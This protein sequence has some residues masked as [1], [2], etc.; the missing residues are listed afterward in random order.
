MHRHSAFTLVEL[1]VVIGVITVLI[2]MLSPMLARARQKSRS[3]ECQSSLRQLY[4]AQSYYASD[5][6]GVWSAP[7]FQGQQEQW[8]ARLARYFPA[9]EE[10][11]RRLMQCGEIDASVQPVENMSYGVNSSLLMPQWSRRF[12]KKYNS[13]R[14]IFMGEKVPNPED[15]L[16]TDDGFY[17]VRDFFGNTRWNNPIG[18]SGAGAFRHSRS[19]ANFVMADG[20]VHALE[21][22]QLH[23]DSGH[24][25]F[26][27]Y[28]GPVLSFLANCCQ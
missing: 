13:S 10:T 8:P 16:T 26:G 6:K 28:D 21:R 9:G 27:V 5:N 4:L 20:S 24:W 19:T 17:F 15:W 25:Y 3:I 14:L 12:D 18:H 1:L 22:K 7:E 2:G 11:R 23:R